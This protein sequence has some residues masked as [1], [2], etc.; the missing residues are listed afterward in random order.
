M[1]I[2]GNSHCGSGGTE[3]ACSGLGRCGDAGLVPGSGLKDVV[4]PGPALDVPSRG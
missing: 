4:L 2:H 3:P 1:N